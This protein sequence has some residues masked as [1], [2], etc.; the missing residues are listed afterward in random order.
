MSHA[1]TA[2]HSHLQGLPSQRLL[3]F[4]RARRWRLSHLLIQALAVVV[5]AVVLL[6]LLYLAIRGFGAGEAGLAYL[7]QPRTLTIVSNSLNLM[8]AVTLS[9]TLIGV[10]F[11]WLTSRTD[12][13]LRRVWLVLGLLT[14]V[15][16]SY[17]GAI[18]YVEAFGPRGMLQS[19]L[20]PFGVE[21]LPEIRG[22][23]GAWLSITL[24]SYPYVVLPIRAALLNA[25]PS[26]EEVG[27]SMGFS[28]WRVFWRITLPQLRPALAIGIL[29]TA[30]YTLSDF[31][32]VAVMR[33]NAF[34]RAI[35]QQ[36]NN[37]FNPERAALLALVLVAITL[38]LLYV[39]QRINTTS[40][41]Y[42]VGTGTR[43]ALRP[44]KLGRWR[45]P[46]LIF[47]GVIVFVGVVVPFVVLMVWLFG[48]VY[49]DPVP[50]SMVNLTRNTV[51]VSLVAAIV[52]ALV[53]LPIGI[54]ASKVPTRFNR[55]L[56]RLT[57]LSNVLPSL[58]IALALVFF[59][60][61]YLPAWYQTFPV[62]ILG[63][64]T[65]FLPFSIGTTQSAL[66]QINPRLEEASRSLGNGRWRT[67]WRVTVP[68]A[69]SGISAGTALVFL[70]VMKELPITLVL[71]PI[72]FR[73]LAGRIWTVQNEAMF[74]LVGVPGFLLMLASGLALFIILR[75]DPRARV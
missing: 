50:V 35:F 1:T 58:V 33:Y 61:N 47:C 39:E 29:M 57:Y 45:V 68:L 53:A 14:M 3:S 23:F 49:N 52:S 65:R 24:F 40:A 64:V 34:T 18:T 19:L 71:S 31:G 9:A 30:L 8:L 56:V 51:S 55:T 75:S 12:L 42:R 72:G 32:A 6:P 11:A 27:R 38:C 48:R 26:M 60:A 37:S 59:M 5:V 69:F 17:L 62:L 15:I 25:D 16:P 73:T 20:A 13:P 54:L 43:R 70:N 21:R 46:S 41:N 74:V 7:L 10:P 36:Y 4:L 2:P 28:R 66:T 67:L 22:F 63:Y 44:V